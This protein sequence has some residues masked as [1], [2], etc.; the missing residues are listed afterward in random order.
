MVLKTR[1]LI[2]QRTQ[3]VNALRAHL[4]ELVIV[5]ASGLPNVTALVVI[6]RKCDDARLPAAARFALTAVADQ[7]DD[8]ERTSIAE[9]KRDDDMRACRQ[10]PASVSSPRQAL[11]P[12]PGGFKW[13]KR[14][15]HRSSFCR[16]IRLTSSRLGGLL[17]RK[18]GLAVWKQSK[19]RS[20][21]SAIASPLRSAETTSMLPHMGPIAGDTLLS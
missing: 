3:P 17:L 13:S 16:R 12:D 10:F 1:A 19:R 4:A 11:V 9:V 8:L 14:R 7:I 18:R 21:T 5:A 20:G 6:V 15:A 2:Q